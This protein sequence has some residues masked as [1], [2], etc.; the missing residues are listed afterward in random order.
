[1]QHARWLHGQLPNLVEEGLLTP[2]L[3]EQLRQRFP[4]ATE[5]GRSARLVTLVIGVLGSA[6]IGSGII[7]LLAHNWDDLSRA[8]RTVIALTPLCLA[9]VAA[10]WALWRRASRAWCEGVAVFWVFALGAALALIEQTYHF[11]GPPDGLLLRWLL[12]GLP[13]VYLLRS[14]TAAC[15]AC[16][17]IAIWTMMSFDI[18]HGWKSDMPLLLVLLLVPFLFLLR[19]DGG[20]RVAS[21]CVSWALVLPTFLAFVS[22]LR[23][24]PD[25]V[26]ALAAAFVFAGFLAIDRTADAEQQR[27]LARPWWVAA[28]LGTVGFLLALSFDE[29][30]PLMK[31]FSELEWMDAL[32]G[33]GPVFLLFAVLVR[34][35]WKRRRELGFE[36][37]WLAVPL[38]FV[39][40]TFLGEA[41]GEEGYQLLMNLLL[42]ALGIGGILLSFRSHSL[43]QLNFGLGVVTLLAIVRFF[44][45]GIDFSVRGVAFILVGCLFFGLNAALVR[46][47]RALS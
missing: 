47:R 28:R 22:P 4:V 43:L 39:T 41:V 6:L 29:A 18:G 7:L 33:L 20:R 8:A 10:C 3:A 12:L 15:L 25:P 11:G 44:D 13:I 1:M 45:S 34:P 37:A 24:L 9:Q 46:R 31:A 14:A 38:A 42:L 27:V 40:V 5:E 32:R 35:L 2:Q 26:G 36:W 16:W 21:R 30:L 17:G 23:L 19:R